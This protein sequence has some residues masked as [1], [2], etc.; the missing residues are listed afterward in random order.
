[1]SGAQVVPIFAFSETSEIL[2]LLGKINGVLFT[3][4]G[5]EFSMNNRWTKNA[6]AI[7]KYA[8]EE[9]DR[10]N[11]FPIWATCLGF[12]LMSFLTG[13][14]VDTLTRVQGD[15]AIVLPINIKMPS[16]YIYS[17]MTPYQI[18]K[19][20]KGGGI[21]YYNHNWAVTVNTYNTNQKLK[22]F[23]NMV[24][25][26]TSHGDNVDF[27]CTMEAK[28][29]PFYGVQFHPEKNLFEWKVSAD[30]SL[31]GV[32]VIQIMSN[33]FIEKAR[34]SNHRF[35]TPEEFSKISIYNY[36]TYQTD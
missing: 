30:R 8:M 36:R 13:G 3:G 23:W 9:N 2:T 16:S 17:A 7:V 24:A 1:M 21:L 4:G 20:T 6:D 18:E 12:Q 31:E 10:G 15:G 34:A 19:M 26:S 33:R 14:Y 29:Y 25:T 28:K 22:N 5:M 11:V 32:E 27:V 35:P